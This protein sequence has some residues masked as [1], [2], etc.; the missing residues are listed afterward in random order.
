MLTDPS[1][2]R[3][4]G[5]FSAFAA[6]FAAELIDEGYTPDSAGYQMRL[7]A[8]LSRWLLNKELG[9]GDIR[10]AEVDRFCGPVVRPVA[11]ISFRLRGCGHCSLTCATLE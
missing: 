4:T 2:V 10:A 7:M 1:R 8:H 3:V 9:A 6:G 11:R 5:P